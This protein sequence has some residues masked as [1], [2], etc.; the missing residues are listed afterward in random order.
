MVSGRDES[1]VGIAGSATEGTVGA[2]ELQGRPIARSSEILET[3]PGLIITQHSGAGKANQYYLRGF[4]LDHGT[5][6]AGY[7]NGVPINLPT[8]AHGQGYLDLNWLIPELVKGVSYQ[9]GVYYADQGDFSNAGS[10]NVDSVSTLPEN[11]A[12]AQVGGLGYERGLFAGSTPVA[13]GSLLYAFEAQ[14]D[15]GAW[16]V[17][18][19]YRRLNGVVRYGLGDDQKGFSLSAQGYHGAWFATD[20]IPQ[21]AIDAGLSRFSTFDPS[22]GG[23]T[24][25]YGLSGD[26]HRRDQDSASKV[27]VYLTQYN[28]DL[29]SNFT[30]FLNQVTGDQIDQKDS[31]VYTG[32][33]AEHTVY[34]KLFERDMENTFGLQV[35]QDWI[36]AT[37]NDTQNRNLVSH[38]RTDHVAELNVSPW[39]Q[40]KLQWSSWFRTVEGVR[41]DLYD[42]HVASDIAPDSGQKFTGTLNPKLSLILGPWDK[43]EFYLSGGTGFRTNDA[44]GIFAVASPVQGEP[45]RQLPAI[46]HTRGAEV[47]VRSSRLPGLNTTLS[48]WVLGSESDTFFSGDSGSVVDADRAGRRYGVE[49]TNYFTPRPWLTFDADFAYS[50]SRFVDDD[51]KGVGK[52]I[53]E[54][55]TSVISGAVAVHDVPGAERVFGALRM[56]QFGPRPL[57]ED[58]SQKSAPSTVFNIEAG[59]HLSKAW[60]ASLQVLNLFNS[61]YRE[62][63]YYYS[64]RLK[65]EA[66]GPDEQGGTNDHMVHS[67]EPRSLRATLVAKF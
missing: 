52:Y 60:T 22:S 61:S 59:Y 64:S 42:F 35:R 13:A 12:V 6:L 30:Y 37:L 50:T 44:R 26:W 16:Q 31:R 41:G 43:T 23:K 32:V 28:L 11:L 56:R 53:P 3:V 7:V 38:V 51:P 63:E 10:L 2:A 55:I 45:S 57:I 34:G 48:F 65:G 14:H 5:D 18:N 25:R 24:G 17:A 67:G 58:N 66:A 54:A 62:N 36:G 4:N 20:Q 1:L 49:W 29:Y 21:R 40:H 8:H 27:V 19:N 9:K 33:R 46:V 15:D 47:G 39:F